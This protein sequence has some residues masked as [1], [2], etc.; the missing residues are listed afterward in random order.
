M[1]LL[2]N[3]SASGG[4]ANK[5]WNGIKHSI[6]F[7]NKKNIH[8]LNNDEI[9]KEEIQNALSE[10]ERKFIA[11]G[12]DG[13][14]NFLLN[15]VLSNSPSDYQDDLNIGAIGLGSSNDFHKPMKSIHFK[16]NISCKIDFNS[17]VER[18]IGCITL[19]HKQQIIKKYFLINASIG[20]TAEA[21]YLF[22]YPGTFLRY[23]KNISTNTA[24][25]YS[26]L[27]TIFKYKNIEL[28]MI[29]SKR[30][31][32]AIEV[33][34]LAITKSPHISGDIKLDF[35]PD[36]ADSLFNIHLLG[37]ISKIELIKTLFRLNQK[38]ADTNDM[39]NISKES[40]LL[41]T[42]EKPFKVE[43]DG[44]IITTHCARFSISPKRIRICMN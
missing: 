29:D 17:T 11:A 18:D 20:V 30:N 37:D 22:N 2:V 40:S 24:I 14:I 27:C 31:F 4:K 23:L 34:N 7:T 12:G 15:E 32:K 36:Y 3:T 43:Y 10:G 33:A 35:T 26:A 16:K 13:T 8:Y 6:P 9:A 25:M 41:V 5:K 44:E 21:N 38:K 39:F 19:V 42:A 1:F 28:K